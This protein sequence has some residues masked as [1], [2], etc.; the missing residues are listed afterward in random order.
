MVRIKEKHFIEEKLLKNW[1]LHSRPIQDIYSCWKPQWAPRISCNHTIS[2]STSFLD[3]RNP[4]CAKSIQKNLNKAN[5][6]HWHCGAHVAQSNVVDHTKNWATKAV[7]TFD[8]F[9]S[10]CGPFEW[11]AKSVPFCALIT[12]HKNLLLGYESFV[13]LLLSENTNKH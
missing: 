11:A 7:W 6:G 2:K 8:G 10:H 9:E 4:N 13:A 1:N 12:L 3:Q 5:Y